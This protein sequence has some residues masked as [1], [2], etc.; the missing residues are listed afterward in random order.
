MFPIY[1]REGLI[2]SLFKKEDGEDPGNYRGITL[3]RVTG[4][5]YN[6]AINNYLFK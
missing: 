5:L 1:W 3:L 6:R 4:K 2:V